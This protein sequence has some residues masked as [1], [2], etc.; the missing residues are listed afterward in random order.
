MK[1]KASIIVMSHLSD[2]NI[3]ININSIQA[4]KR[5]EFV[6][7]LVFKLNGNLNQEIEP[8][9]YW[10]EFIGISILKSKGE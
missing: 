9:K 3:E 10:D 1:T 2:A 7:F 8:D 4:Q 6:K 5:I